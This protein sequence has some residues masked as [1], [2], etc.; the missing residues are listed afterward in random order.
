LFF[1]IGTALC[2]MLATI[3]PSYAQQTQPGG[4]PGPGGAP[5]QAPP[6]IPPNPLLTSWTAGPD[7]VGSSTYVGRVDTPRIGA[8]ISTA[9]GLLVSGW[10]VDTTARGWAG[11]DGVDL[12]A[13]DKANGG[14]K[15][16][17]GSVGLPRPDIGDILGSSFTNSGF[18]MVVPPSAWANI[19]AG[20]VE[21]RLY[22]HTPSK[23]T[24]YR[25]TRVTSIQ[26]P[27]LPYP[28]DPM[29]W[30]SKPQQGV[31]IT[32]RQPNNKF[33]FSGNVLDRNP[34]S[35]VQN[36]LSLLPPGIGQTLS[37]GCNACVG[38]TGNI[39]TQFRGAGAN[40]IVAYIDSPPK[41]GDIT[42]F[43]NFGAPCTSCLAGVSILVNNAGFLNRAD[44][45][46]GSVVTDSYGVP[47]S[48]DPEQF[49][50]AGWVISINP[51]LL[52]PGPHTLYVTGISAIT[53]K[54]T[55]ASVD[56]N[57]IPYTNPS[58]RIQP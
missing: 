52:N 43:G 22:I 11:V 49:R 3:A 56:F 32:Q 7:A 2:L 25:A 15:L 50:F 30:I 27:A 35:A 42:Q 31:N 6:V 57:I 40:S 46:Q 8:V 9:N 13:G 39:Y 36:S 23:G 54:T 12:Y 33:T 37:T 14:T 51:A 44:K 58:Q 20:N 41:P 18:S 55:T 24:W 28:T 29:V 4:Q 48:G 34:L 10:A 21:L 45:P 16:G 26:P 17:S 53:G 1:G 19:P 47:I 38:A 5:T